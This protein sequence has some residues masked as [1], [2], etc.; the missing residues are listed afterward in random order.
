MSSKNYIPRKEEYFKDWSINLKTVLTGYG[1][2]DYMPPATYHE[3]M[4]LG[5]DYETKIAITENNLTRT[6]KTIKD[7]Q[8]ARKK[9]EKFIRDMIQTYLVKNPNLTDGQKIAAG[10]PVY[11]TT[12]TPSPVD[13]VSPGFKIKLPSP[14]VVEIS[15]F[16]AKNKKTAKP[17]GQHGARIRWAILDHPTED[18]NEL[19]HSETETHSPY[20]LKFEGTD[21]GKTIY[22]ALC[23]VNTR[24]ENGDFSGISSAIIP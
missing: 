9:Y 13:N 18:W 16:D 6:T 14:G 12:R 10:I 24:E 3:F 1:A 4:R 2:E 20:R 19:I 7:R 15:F 23:W 5:S 11:K 21:R 8:E 17:E 22:F